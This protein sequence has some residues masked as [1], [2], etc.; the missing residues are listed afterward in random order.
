MF[1]RARA[2]MIA[3][4]VLTLGLA[5]A[6]GCSDA[7]TSACTVGAE[8]DCL[9]VPEGAAGKETCL[10]NQ[11]WGP[12]FHLGR[13]DGGTGDGGTSD[14]VVGDGPGG[15]SDRVEAS[16]GDGPTAD[17]VSP[18]EASAG[19]GAPGTPCG[20]SRC[21]GLQ[22]CVQRTPIGPSTSFTCESVIKGCEGSSLR[23]CACLGTALCL[24]AFNVCTDVGDNTIQC[25]CPACQ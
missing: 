11:T 20:N 1:L 14:A 8:R 12:C 3:A 17:S 16:V 23:T 10:A 5:G 24:G 22:V 4:A 13:S 6:A 19:D 21:T 9:T 7:T 25:E 18:L 15:D 2:K